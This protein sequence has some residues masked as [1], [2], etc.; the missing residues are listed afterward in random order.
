MIY[1]PLNGVINAHF[2]FLV[3]SKGGSGLKLSVPT[4]AGPNWWDLKT[5]T[6]LFINTPGWMLIYHEI[7]WRCAE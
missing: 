3:E 7:K 1:T 4:N 2:S 6:T 5:M